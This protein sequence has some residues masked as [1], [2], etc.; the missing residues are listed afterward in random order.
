MWFRTP[1]KPVDA[2]ITFLIA[3]ALQ[4]YMLAIGI[5]ANIMAGKDPSLQGHHFFAHGV[6]AGFGFL[7]SLLLF[8][9][10]SVKLISVKEEQRRE[11]RKVMLWNRGLM[12]TL[13]LVF[14]LLFLRQ[15][16]R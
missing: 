15:L 1:P 10:G 9:S 12:W 6:L 5:H 11:F 3:L 13:G 14:V 7:A 8:V 16:F 4:C 2:L